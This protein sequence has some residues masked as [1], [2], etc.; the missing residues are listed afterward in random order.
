VVDKRKDKKPGFASIFLSGVSSSFGKSMMKMD[1]KSALSRKTKFSRN[2][3]GDTQNNLISK[4]V[5]NIP[6]TTDE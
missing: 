1:A 5:D 6:N 4:T 3:R 2:K